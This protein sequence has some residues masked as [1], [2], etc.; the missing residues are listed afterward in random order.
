MIDVNW[1]EF[2]KLVELVRSH[3][4]K[5]L[6]TTVGDCKVH[7]YYRG[8]TTHIELTEGRKHEALHSQQVQQPA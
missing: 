7:I 3:K 8:L 4:V 2:G 1:V 5:M 6:E